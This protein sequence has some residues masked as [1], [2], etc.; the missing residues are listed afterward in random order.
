MP[1]NVQKVLANPSYQRLVETRRRLAI[2]L[3][4]VM[5]AAYF[6]F[7]LVIA[8]KP[9]LLGTPLVTGGITTVGIPVG[10]G[11]ILLAIILTAVYTRLSN[12]VFDALT[13]QAR[14]DLKKE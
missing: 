5:L 3:S 14:K 7:I 4:A 6:G 1:I 11:L 2:A 13:E 8:F 12:E 9:A 10:V